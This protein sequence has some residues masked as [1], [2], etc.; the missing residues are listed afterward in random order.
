MKTLIVGIARS[1]TSALYFKLKQA[2]PETTWCLYEPPCFD[3]SDPGGSPSVLAKIVIGPPGEFDYTSFRDFDKKIMIVRDPRDN[4]VSRVLYGP[5]ATEVFRR[6]KAKIARFYPGVA[7]QGG[8]SRQHIRVGVDRV[9]S[10]PHR[11][12]LGGATVGAFRPGA[13]L[14]PDE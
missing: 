3:S 7:L 5:C 6:D 4:V 11:S 12:K 10:Q 2:L 1:G 13:G 8:R 14:P 9:V